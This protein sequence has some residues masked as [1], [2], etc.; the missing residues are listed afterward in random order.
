MKRLTLVFLIDA[1][2]W[3]LLD[4]HQFL[5]ELAHRRALRT[6]AGFS[7]AA[8][9]TL[10]TGRWPDEHGRWFLYSRNPGETPFGFA[11]FLAPACAL[12]GM[13]HRI[14]RLY[15]E[16][17]AIYSGINEYYNL[18]EIP[19]PLLPQFDLPGRNSI[20][21]PHA[22]GGIPNLFDRVQHH[23]IP[24]ESWNWSA[25]EEENVR[26]LARSVSEGKMPF[27]FFYSPTLD[28]IMHATGTDS[29]ETRS[30][31]EGYQSLIRETIRE[32]RKKYDDMAVYICSDHGMVNVNRVIDLMTEIR[33]LPFR[34]G[35][36]YLP[37]YDSTF[38][39]F[40]FFDEKAREA[41]NA[42]LEGAEG[43]RLLSRKEL[44]DL[45][46]YFPSGDY[47]ESI[48]L[49]E[50]GTV[51]APSFMG[52]G[53]PLAMH[54]YHP[55]D[56]GSDGILLSNREIPSTVNHIRNMAALLEEGAVWAGGGVQDGA[57]A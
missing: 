5:P 15:E 30:S 50:A 51:I 11:R 39:R 31:I 53:A 8:I 41:I 29:E 40:W 16:L 49:T 2:A 47:G 27:L 3:D 48:F 42:K 57:R 34:E 35:K 23:A 26:S 28:G 24:Y 25:S 12:P 52:G 33:K 54:G 21:E 18:Y 20:Y 19:L 38:A 7:S 37:F 43:G 9:P 45:H 14:R 13:G 36:D 44:V 55:D 22:V 17:F 6:V 32:A 46:L 4:H 56:P 10:L 1:F